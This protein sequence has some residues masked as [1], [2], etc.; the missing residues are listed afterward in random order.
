MIVVL[1][2]GGVHLSE[3]AHAVALLS[4]AVPSLSQAAALVSLF[5]LLPEYAPSCREDVGLLCPGAN[6]PLQLR[7]HWRPVSLAPVPHHISG[8][9]DSWAAHV[10]A[11]ENCPHPPPA[12]CLTLPQSKCITH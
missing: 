7:R 3:E 4:V 2:S 6:S 5:A 10:P 12:A 11:D 9:K 1:P 8:H